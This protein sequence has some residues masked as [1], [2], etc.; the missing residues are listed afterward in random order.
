MKKTLL[1]TILILLSYCCFSQNPSKEEIQISANNFLIQLKKTNFQISEII[2]ETTKNSNHLI[3]INL[4]P[5]V[6]L[7]F[8]NNFNLPPII[9]YSFNNYYD[10]AL[11]DFLKYDIDDRTKNIYLLS[12]EQKNKNKNL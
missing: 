12:S 6:F 9:Y 10:D 7:I 4:A 5:Q 2:Y 11:I 8:T 3:I 1:F